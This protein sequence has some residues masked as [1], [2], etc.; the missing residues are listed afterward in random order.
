MPTILL[1]LEKGPLQI[2]RGCIEAIG[3]IGGSLQLDLLMKIYNSSSS[4]LRPSAEE[5]IL[6]ILNKPD[7]KANIDLVLR[8]YELKSSRI[9]RAAAEALSG[10]KGPR[11]INGLMAAL[12]DDNLDI[13]MAGIDGIIKQLG[14]DFDHCLRLLN[15]NQVPFALLSHSDYVVRRRFALALLNNN[16]SDEWILLKLIGFD[17]GDVRLPALKMYLDHKG[18]RSFSAVIRALS[19]KDIQV[20]L[21]SIRVLGGSDWRALTPLGRLLSDPSRDVRIA[22]IQSLEEIAIKSR[23][24]FR[25]E[26][27]DDLSDRLG[28]GVFSSR[29]EKDPAVLEHIRRAYNRIKES[30]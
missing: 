19:D 13:Q 29:K 14:M 1:L 7:V 11:A 15:E 12:K 18:R 17:D 8:L 30:M 27:L 21:F 9:K 3:D 24:K 5:H 6:K 2:K 4:Y 26:V 10:I 28:L 25:A 16:I 23:Q 22:V 20:R